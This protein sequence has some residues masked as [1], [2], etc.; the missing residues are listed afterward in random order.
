MSHR[1]SRLPI[2]WLVGAVFTSFLVVPSVFAEDELFR[3]GLLDFHLKINDNGNVSNVAIWTPLFRGGIGRTDPTQGT[4]TEYAG[5]FFRPLVKRPNA[6]DLVLAVQT[7]RSNDGTALEVQAEYR[8]PPGTLTP[9]SLGL[10]GGYVKQDFGPTIRFL[11]TSYRD[12]I[13]NALNVVGSLQVQETDQDSSVG[14]YFALYGT[15]LMLAGGTDGEQWRSAFGYIHPDRADGGMRPA[16]EVFRVDQ[17]IGNLDGA[18]FQLAMGTL[19]YSSGGFLQHESRLGRALGPQGLQFTNPVG[20]LQPM[21]NRL[22]TVPEIG[23]L[24]SARVI[25]TKLPSGFRFRESELIAYPFQFR[26]RSAL[27]NALFVGGGLRETTGSDDAPFLVGG[28]IGSFGGLRLIAESQ[29]DFETDELRVFLTVQ[30]FLVP[31]E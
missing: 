14:G 24:M 17:T 4:P 31:H 1:Q 7:T 25:E 19:R 20:F 13:G 30:R 23:S 15:S 27:G 3:P 22:A 21:W 16:F 5:G 28:A 26:E 8:L 10:G 29:W 6:G 12:T 9:G 11:K 2:T 18:T